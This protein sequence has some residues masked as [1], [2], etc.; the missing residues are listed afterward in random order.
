[1]ETMVDRNALLRNIPQVEKFLQEP[2]LQHFIAA[3]GRNRVAD[4]VREEIDALRARIVAG[5]EVPEQS[6]LQAVLER[7]AGKNREKIQRVINATGVLIHTNLG[8]A[9]LSAPI[10]NDL[11]GV[12]A[13]YCNL[14][15]RLSDGKRGYRGGF[16]E[17]LICRLTG[18]EDALV[19]NN[20]ASS[21]FLILSHFARGREVIVSRGELIQIGGGFRI[22]DIM[23]ETGALLVEVG[24]TN[25]TELEDVRAAIGPGTG[26]IFSAHQSNYQIEGF[27]HQPAVRDLAGL[28]SEAVLL[29][30]DLGS[31]NLVADHELPQPFEPT[32]R[33]ELAQG[34]DLVCFS[35]D[36]LLG[37]CQAGIIVGRAD[38]IAALRKNPMMR[39]LRVDKVTSFILQETLLRYESGS[40]REIG[41]WNLLLQDRDALASKITRVQ[42]RVRRPEGKKYLRRV[43]LTALYGGGSLPSAELPSLGL[44]VEVPGRT[45]DEVA[46]SFLRAAVPVVGTIAGG[47]FT[48]NFMTLLDRDI[49]DIAAAIDSLVDG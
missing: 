47:K 9:P 37:A 38:L 33:A 48:L 19:V 18:A 27:A 28:K 4:I 30:R 23:R 35:G 11:A 34:A 46:D 44:Q 1:M 25:V 24:A 49:P 2:P 14:E 20:N 32:V 22:P 15:L 31:G 8:R 39:M 40:H 6:L 3:I 29:V 13:G 36:K 17:E 5:D 42:R 21:V 16:S 7:C 41:L 45:A 26:M 12:M 10:L 43:S